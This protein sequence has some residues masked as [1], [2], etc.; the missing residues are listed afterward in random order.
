[1]YENRNDIL[2]KTVASNGTVRS[3]KFIKVGYDF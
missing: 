3:F 1:M 2:Q